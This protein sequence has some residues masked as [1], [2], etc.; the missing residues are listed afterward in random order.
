MVDLKRNKW[1]FP[2]IGGIITLI[3]FYTPA[4]TFTYQSPSYSTEFYRWMLDF[5]I[6]HTY[7]LGVHTTRMGLNTSLTG[8]ISWI[9]SF[10]ILIF[11]IFIIVSANKDRKGISVSRINWLVV[12]L[13]TVIL[14][15]G[16]MVMKEITTL[17]SFE[18]S[19]WGL[20]SPS[21]G[22]IG[23]YL[24]AG[25]EIIGFLLSKSKRLRTSE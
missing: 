11:N 8:W 23:L 7:E 1:F 16:W 12:A 18:H 5:Y 19:F 10:L 13:L 14:T 2:F 22:I 3:S 24:G 21:F 20:L 4:A 6:S 15:I 17:I 25:L 9:S